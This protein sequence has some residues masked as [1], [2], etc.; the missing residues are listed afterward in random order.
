MKILILNGPNL[1][2]LG[3]R[4]PLVYGNLSFDEFYATLKK[5]YADVELD[6]FQSNIEGEIIDK[7]HEVGYSYDGIVINAGAYTHT[8]IAI[9]DALRAFSGY[10]IE[11][12]ISNPHLRESFRH[13][14]YIS[15]AVDAV[16]AG[17]GI[18][19]YEHVID[20]LNEVLITQPD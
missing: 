5:K 15:P 1:N 18:D 2:L 11:L 12:H 9:H 8:S 13:L 7:L 19:G 10:K 17:L 20:I 4:E 16:V 3:R 6:Y 14:S